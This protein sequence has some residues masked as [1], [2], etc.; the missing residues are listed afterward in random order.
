[1]FDLEADDAVN[2]GA[3]GSIIGHE[4]GHGFDEQGSKFDSQGNLKDWW[5]AAD[6]KQFEGRAQC[7]TDQFN[8]L[9]VGNGLRH[10]G[11]LVV[12]EALGDLGGLGLAYR[13]YKRSLKGKDGPVIDGFT[14]DQR[15]FLAFAR[16]FGTNV[17]SEALR[18]QLNTDPHPVPKFRANGT[19]QNMPEFHKAFGCKAGD[20]MVRAAEKL[21]RLW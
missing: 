9:D 19:L 15:F 10:N 17:R 20:A 11:S 21:C 1:M 14:A 4:L 8:T 16:A 18:L 6:R 3:I 7:V 5:T 12:G 2:Y 13:A